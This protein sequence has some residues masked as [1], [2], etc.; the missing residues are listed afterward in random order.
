[1]KFARMSLP[2]RGW[3]ENVV[4]VVSVWEILLRYDACRVVEKNGQKKP[5]L[6]ER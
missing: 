4:S 5:R 6:A 2:T 3:E 1:M